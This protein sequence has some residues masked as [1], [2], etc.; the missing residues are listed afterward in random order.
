MTITNTIKKTALALTAVVATAAPGMAQYTTEDGFKVYE[1]SD[2][3]GPHAEMITTLEK[4]GVPVLNGT[5][6]DRLCAPADEDGTV[7]LGWYTPVHNVVV[8]CH[9]DYDQR[10]QTLTH[11]VVHVI[12][13]ARAGLD[14]SEMGE[15]SA[16]HFAHIESNISDR[17]V[18]TITNLYDKEDW[19]VEAEAFFYQ[20]SP[21][22]VSDALKVFTF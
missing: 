5:D 16:R 21:E 14:N 1:A 10:A 3:A 17:K 4:L 13:D 18:W 9:G 22:Q 15:V 12:Q 11:E 20:D 2:F 8:L 19:V 6:D 7:T